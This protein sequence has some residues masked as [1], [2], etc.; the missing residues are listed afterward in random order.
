MGTTCYDADIHPGGYSIGTY[1]GVSLRIVRV[2]QPSDLEALYRFRHEIYVAQMGWYPP[3]PSGRLMDDFDDIAHNFAALDNDGCVVGS[4]RVVPDNPIGLPLERYAP[5][6]GYR[7]GK[8]PFEI[9]RLAVHPSARKTNLGARMMKTSFMCIKMSGGSHVV[10]DTQVSGGTMRLY[11][12]AGFTRIGGEYID[13][14]VLALRCV[15][16]SQRVADM[17][18]VWPTARPALYRFFTSD[19]PSIYLTGAER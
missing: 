1:W 4:V 10:L 5:L 16:L 9:C 13:D 17:Y 15:T 8:T 14:T 19:D 3:D 18:E 6:N 2:T 7:A 12:K 11:E